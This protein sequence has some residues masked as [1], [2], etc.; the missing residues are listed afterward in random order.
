MLKIAVSLLTVFLYSQALAYYP[1]PPHPLR[2]LVMES[3][4]IVR[5]K[6]IELGKEEGKTKDQQRWEH[7]YAIIRVSNVLQ[8]KVKDEEIKVYFT[9][10]MI[11]PAPGVFYANEEVLAFL[12]KYE[13]ENFYSVHALSYGVKHKLDEEAFRCYTERIA[14]MQQLLKMKEGDEQ[15]K[16]ILGWLVKCAEQ[17]STRWEGTYELSSESGFFSYYENNQWH[18]KTLFLSCAQRQRL[19]EALLK[20]E[21]LNS[22]D[23]PLIDLSKGF[24]EDSVFNLLKK[25]LFHLKKEEPWMADVILQKLMPFISDPE[26]DK[27]YALFSKLYSFEEKDKEEKNRLLEILK[28][29]IKPADRRKALPAVSQSAT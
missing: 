10:R 7:E 27:T 26:A 17:K 28:E 23:I 8:G 2:V 4:Y 25:S 29:R 11:C 12:D 3:K 14:E 22:R 24:N 16:E 13:G 6:V 21:V 15:D 9:S 18:R 1:I 19:S 5:G 20:E